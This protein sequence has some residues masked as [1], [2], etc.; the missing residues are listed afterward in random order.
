MINRRVIGLIPNGCAIVVDDVIPNHRYNTW[1]HMHTITC[2]VVD[3]VIENLRVSPT[4]ADTSVVIHNDI[5]VRLIPIP[6]SDV[7]SSFAIMHGHSYF[8]TRCY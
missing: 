1:A 6:C 3:R 8:G 4:N 5:V 7:E 2:I